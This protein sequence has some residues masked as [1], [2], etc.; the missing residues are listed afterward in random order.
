MQFR[1]LSQQY[2]NISLLK[3]QWQTVRN[4]TQS[5]YTLIRSA[6]RSRTAAPVLPAVVLA[7]AA[8]S[9]SAQSARQF[10]AVNIGTTIPSPQSVELTM[11]QAG[12]ITRFDRVMW[13]TTS[14]LPENSMIGRVFQTLLGYSDQPTQLQLTVYLG[15]LVVIFALMKLMAPPPRPVQGL[16]THKA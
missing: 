10:P 7:L 1:A 8:G 2:R 6:I 4:A 5:A 15:T 12:I 11:Q 3:Q 16:A 13:D 9:A 14:F